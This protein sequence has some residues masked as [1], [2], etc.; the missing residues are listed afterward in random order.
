MLKITEIMINV[1][2]KV[3]GTEFWQN[4]SIYLE[5]GKF[6]SCLTEKEIFLWTIKLLNKSYESLR[7]AQCCQVTMPNYNL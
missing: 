6:L 2:N 7:D 4:V 5:N 1:W 3:L